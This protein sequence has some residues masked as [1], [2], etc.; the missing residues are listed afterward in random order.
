[1]SAVNKFFTGLKEN[2]YAIRMSGMAGNLTM[3]ATPHSTTTI[4]TITTKNNTTTTTTTRHLMNL[5]L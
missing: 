1:M 5:K 3:N 4:T 2:S